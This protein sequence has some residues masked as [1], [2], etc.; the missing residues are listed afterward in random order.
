M[1]AIN[2]A[3]RSGVKNWPSRAWVPASS[4]ASV[5]TRR[6]SVRDMRSPAMGTVYPGL[7][8]SQA[9]PPGRIP[10]RRWRRSAQPGDD[11]SSPDHATAGDT[12]N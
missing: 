2:W 3:A 8:R 10:A 12:G 1:P 5:A 11:A 9:A 7:R 4:S 6:A